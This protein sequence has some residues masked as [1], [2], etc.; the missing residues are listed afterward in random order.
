[1]YYELSVFSFKNFKQS[2]IIIYTGSH[3]GKMFD[4]VRRYYKKHN[5]NLSFRIS[6]GE[7][8]YGVL[9]AGLWAGYINYLLKN[10]LS[11]PNN[12]NIIIREYKKL[13]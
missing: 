10:S 9:I 11:L 6:K 2:E 3:L 8:I 12:K 1:M 13:S 7:Q 4:K 5:I